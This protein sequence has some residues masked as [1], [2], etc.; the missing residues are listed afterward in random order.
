MDENPY[1]APTARHLTPEL[2]PYQPRMFA[3][4]GRIGRL[5]YAAYTFLASFI[6]MLVA[7]MGGGFL[8]ALLSGFDPEVIVGYA[9]VIG[10]GIYVPPF[11]VFFV[12][13]KRRLNDMNQSGWWSLLVL[14]PLANLALMLYLMLW[15]G[16]VGR[17][18]YGPPP[19]DNP[20][21][22][23][24]I[25]LMLPLIGVA[26]SILGMLLPFMIIPDGVDVS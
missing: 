21:W 14:S 25:G 8:A 18:Y 6:I 2:A 10:V 22:V 4:N 24:V 3:A 15:P 19:D 11:A 9:L 16:T 13:A 7:V 26:L 20:L 23:T 17:N 5:R 1:L 12:M